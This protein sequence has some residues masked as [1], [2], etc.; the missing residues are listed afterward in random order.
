M[1]PLYLIVASAIMAASLQSFAED[2]PAKT[3][4][5]AAKPGAHM[6]EMREKMWTHM[7]TQNAEL[8]Q[9]A[10]AMNSA[11]GGEK[12][13]AIAAVVNKLVEIHREMNTRMLRMHERRIKAGSHMKGMMGGKMMKEEKKGSGITEQEKGTTEEK[14]HQQE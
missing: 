4:E 12:V 8:D 11:E 10:T 14:E 6:M 5:K 2:K 13:E 7:K 3:G 1:K 9:L